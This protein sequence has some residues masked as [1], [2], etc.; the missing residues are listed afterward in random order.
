MEIIFP[1]TFEEA[2][3][4]SSNSEGHCDS[5]PFLKVLHFG[6]FPIEIFKLFL[7]ILKFRMICFD[8][9]LFHLLSLI[10]MSPE[11]Q[12]F[13]FEA[14]LSNELSANFFAYV[15]SVPLS[16]NILNLMLASLNSST[17]LFFPSVSLYGIC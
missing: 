12:F 14:V 17:F 15:I 16:G 11:T 7:R 10:L 6:F 9:N 3:L 8:V 2:I 1:G 13:L 4:S 5:E